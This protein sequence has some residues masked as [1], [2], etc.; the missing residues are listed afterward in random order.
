MYRQSLL[1][2]EN[3]KSNAPTRGKMKY[4]FSHRTLFM[5]E[6]LILTK[7]KHE[8]LLSF[9]SGKNLS[10]LTLTTRLESKLLKSL[11]KGLYQTRDTYLIARLKVC[12]R[13]LN[14]KCSRS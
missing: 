8:F 5:E 7:I 13:V 12:A 3:M 10:K 2:K 6:L 1:L 9:A 4:W 14:R 11:V